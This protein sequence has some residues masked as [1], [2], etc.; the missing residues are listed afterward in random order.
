MNSSESESFVDRTPV[1]QDVWLFVT[2]QQERVNVNDLLVLGVV[3][4]I[5][6]LVHA[7]VLSLSAR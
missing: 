7:D 4:I 5:F 2:Y 1:G 3:Y 6:N